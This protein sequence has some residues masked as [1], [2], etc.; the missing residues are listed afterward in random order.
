MVYYRKLV[1]IIVVICEN[2]EIIFLALMTAM[3]FGLVVSRYVFSYSFAWVEELTRYLMIWA[4]YLGA[5]ALFKD[6]DHIRMGLLYNKI[7]EKGRAILDLVMGM[8]Q[9][10]FMATLIILGFQYSESVRLFVVVTLNNLS[11]YWVT[12]IIP[13]SAILMVVILLF[14]LIHTAMRLAGKFMPT[15]PNQSEGRI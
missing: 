14:N 2:I 3:V 6:D 5:A 10:A 12:L 1:E 9:L 4:A 8:L 15:D 11:M 7:P 13:I